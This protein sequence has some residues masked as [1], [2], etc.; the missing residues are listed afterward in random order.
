MLTY[1]LEA[2]REQIQSAF[3][4]LPVSGPK[5]TADMAVEELRI[6]SEVDLKSAC[7]CLKVIKSFTTICIGL[8]NGDLIT[9][10]RDDLRKVGESNHEASDVGGGHGSSKLLQC[11]LRHEVGG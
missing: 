8:S 4:F 10:F 3:Q 1:R 9:R 11:L 6:S 2:E 7:I 5:S